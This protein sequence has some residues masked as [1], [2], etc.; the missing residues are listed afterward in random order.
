MLRGNETTHPWRCPSVSSHF[1]Q[2]LAVSQPSSCWQL[3][4]TKWEQDDPTMCTD[5]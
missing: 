5:G 2:V 1:Q 3:Q 4:R